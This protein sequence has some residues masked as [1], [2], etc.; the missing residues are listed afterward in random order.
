MVRALKYFIGYIVLTLLW[1][2]T[3]INQSNIENCGLLY[4]CTMALLCSIFL[5]IFIFIVEV[6]IKIMLLDTNIEIEWLCIW[7][8]DL[9]LIPFKKIYEFFRMVYSFCRKH[10]TFSKFLLSYIIFSPLLGHV[11]CR[12]TVLTLDS[13]PCFFGYVVMSFFGCLLYTFIDFLYQAVRTWVVG[14]L[15]TIGWSLIK[16]IVKLFKYVFIT[17]PQKLVVKQEKK[18]ENEITEDFLLKNSFDKNQKT[19]TFEQTIHINGKVKSNVVISFDPIGQDG[20]QTLNATVIFYNVDGQDFVR[21]TFNHVWLTKQQ[22]YEILTNAHDLK[23]DVP[24]TTSYY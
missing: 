17:Y 19:N 9:I 22:F 7:F 1:S 10:T 12:Y 24:F 14:D 4:G 13:V 8:A 11:F 15:E 3:L 16:N 23:I 18:V 6:I 20:K 5:S 21:R 2:L